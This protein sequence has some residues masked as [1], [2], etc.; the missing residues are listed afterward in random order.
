MTETRCSAAASLPAASVAVHVTMVVPSGNRAGASLAMDA[1]PTASDASA[2]PIS[3]GVP[4]ADTASAAMSAGAE[5]DGGVVSTTTISCVSVALLPAASVAVHVTTVVPSGNRAGASLAMDATPTA[6]DA[7]ASPISTGVPSADTAS[8][9]MSAGAEIDGGVVSTTTTSCSAV[10]VLPASSDTVHVTIVRPSGRTAGASFAT[11]ATGVA[12][13]AAPAP[14]ASPTAIVPRAAAAPSG[15]SASTVAAAGTRT[16]GGVVSTTST[17][18]DAA[19][20]LPDASVA[21]HTT[22]CDPSGNRAGASLETDTSCTS[23]TAGSPRST[24]LGAGEAASNT[25]SGGGAIDGGVVSTTATS[26]VSV[27]WLPAASVAVQVTTVAPIGNRA[28][29][30][31]ATDAIPDPASE[32]AASPSGTAFEAAEAASNATSG[33]ARTDGRTVSSTT[34]FCAAVASLPA[35]SRAVQ[36]TIVAPNGNRAGASLETDITPT[37]SETCGSASPTAVP[38]A[39]A[40]SATISWTAPIAGGIVSRTVTFCVATAMLPAPS[41]AVQM[42]V[43]MPRVNRSGALLS[44]DSMPLASV[45]AARPTLTG[46]SGPVASTVMSAGGTMDG[47]VRSAACA[48]A[49]AAGV[50]GASRCRCAGGSVAGANRSSR[51]A[52]G[53]RGGSGSENACTRWP[54]ESTTYSRPAAADTATSSGSLNCP[55]WMPSDPHDAA[56]APDASSRTMRLLIG[57]AA[58]RPPPGA[59]STPCARRSIPP[60]LESYAA[61]GSPPGPNLLMLAAAG[62][63]TYT[64]PDA[65]TAIPLG[66]ASASPSGTPSRPIS[67]TYVPLASNTCTRRLPVSAT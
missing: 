60:T 28:G 38:A 21:F 62:S 52:G 53:S 41:I 43:L 37:A 35:T 46:V 59:T 5:I 63:D 31:L 47:F 30:S 10:A 25:T 12:S 23:S 50:A 67:E 20:L 15:D 65:P 22:V 26:C 61:S 39:P 49:P 18:C 16:D 7:S 36:V 54:F 48:A 64:V 33:G 42:T 40:A 2:S 32:E 8:A 14:A 51:C 66:E 6:S 45:A 1:T 13:G 55:A 34:T 17:R 4:S 27:A 58:Y 11:D 19:A 24:L 9:A 56:A 3:T 44:S 57:S 29:A